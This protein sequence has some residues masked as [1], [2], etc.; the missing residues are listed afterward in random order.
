MGA[1]EDIAETALDL[2]KPSG[3]GR[4]TPYISLECMNIGASLTLLGVMT[5]LCWLWLWFMIKRQKKWISLVERDNAFWTRKGVVS[6]RFAEMVKHFEA[7]I[8]QKIMIGTW[9]VIGT[10]SFLF[11]VIRTFVH[12]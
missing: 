11:F 10:L 1:L 2:G 8:G 12:R 3:L 7:G 5:A 9:A 6:G 4:I